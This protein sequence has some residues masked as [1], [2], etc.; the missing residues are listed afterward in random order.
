MKLLENIVFDSCKQLKLLKE[1]VQ[2]NKIQERN[3]NLNSL[4]I[5]LKTNN[6]CLLQI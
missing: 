6:D 5:F 4:A 2:A 1:E 3:K